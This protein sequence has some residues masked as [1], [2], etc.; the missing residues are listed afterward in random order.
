MQNPGNT[1]DLV[2]KAEASGKTQGE[3]GAPGTDVKITL[4][5]NGFQVDDGEFRDYNS[6]ENKKFMADLNEGYVPKEL[7]EK[8]KRK[9]GIALSDKRKEDYIPPPPPKYVSYS[10]EGAS[11]GGAVGTGGAVDTNAADGKPAFDASKPK[12]TIRF[13][14]HNGDSA[15][16]DVNLDTKIDALFSYVESV[17]PVAGSYRLLHGFPPK[18]LEDPSAT[19]ASAGVQNAVV[20][21]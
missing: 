2:A 7:A 15:A 19:V 10:G 8:Y 6:P 4:W 16:L 21:Q 12:T 18:A 11:L 14:F 9:V 5:K 3:P 20:K 17:A 1:D 13:R